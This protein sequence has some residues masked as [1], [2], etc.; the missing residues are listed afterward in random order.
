MEKFV[1]RQNIEHYLQLCATTTDDGECQTIINLL[2]EERKKQRD[3][4]DK[5]KNRFPSTLTGVWSPLPVQVAQ[6][7][8]IAEDNAARSWYCNGGCRFQPCERP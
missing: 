2:A 8:T 4:G 5:R 7:R 1:R 6:R 3:A